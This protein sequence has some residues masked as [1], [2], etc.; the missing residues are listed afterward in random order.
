M[1]SNDRKILIETQA[2]SLEKLFDDISFTIDK[3][4]NASNKNN[5]QEFLIVILLKRTLKFLN[6]Y[7]ILIR[8]NLSEPSMAIVRSIFEASLLIRWCL[9]D[10]EN[11]KKYLKVGQS[12]ASKM[13]ENL[14]NNKYY[15]GDKQK[16]LEEA[17]AQSNKDKVSYTQWKEM[18]K[19]TGMTEIFNFVYPVLSAMSHGSLMAISAQVEKSDLSE[20]VDSINIAAS[21]PLANNFANDCYILCGEWI[22]NKKI[23]PAPNLRDLLFKFE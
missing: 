17:Y 15:D 3:L 8:K 1:N 22:Y 23:R 11:V 4:E 6:A 16:K 5:F 10:Q 21:I 20:D 18:A 14:I 9:I 19:V 13:I 7:L 12:S 2:K